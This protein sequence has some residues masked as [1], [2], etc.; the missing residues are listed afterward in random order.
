MT[1]LLAST[2]AFLIITFWMYVRGKE[3]DREI[4]NEPDSGY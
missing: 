4:Y 2:A 3:I 1:I